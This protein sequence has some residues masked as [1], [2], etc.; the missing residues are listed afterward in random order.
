MTVV[1][2]E[3][4]Q[5]VLAHRRLLV[6]MLGRDREQGG[7]LHPSDKLAIERLLDDH[8]PGHA[9]ERYVTQR[10]RGRG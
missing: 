9:G 6:R 3:D 8:D 2:A 7:Y 4:N 5:E 1:P 10:P